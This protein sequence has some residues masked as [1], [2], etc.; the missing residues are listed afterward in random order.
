MQNVTRRQFLAIAA[1][2]I[3]TAATPR[4]AEAMP[5]K[6]RKCPTVKQNGISYLLYQHAAIVT[7]CPARKSVTIPHRIK[8]GGKTYTVSAIWSGAVSHKTARIVLK[9]R[10]L[11]TIED[12]SVWRRKDLTI[13]CSDAETRVWLRRGSRAR[14]K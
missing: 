11:E 3:A 5:A 12:M 2:I 10:D 14:I 13:I 6:F 1:A 7:K 8:L 4:P 9:A